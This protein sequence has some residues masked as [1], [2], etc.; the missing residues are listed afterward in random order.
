[1]SEGKLLNERW[2]GH[3]LVG[4]FVLAAFFFFGWLL[5]SQQDRVDRYHIVAEFNTIKNLSE[6]TQVKLRGFTI[7]QVQQ[8]A[9]D[10]QPAAGEAYFRVVLGIEKTYPVP[11]GTIAEI[12][13]SGL[14]GDTFIHLDV[15]QAD[16]A[17]LPAGARIKG[18]DALGMKELV[19][20]ITEMAHK[21]GGAGE[22]IRRADLGYKLGRLGDSGH[23]VARSLGQV[24]QSADSLLIAS[25]TLLE[26][27]GPGFEGVLASLQLSADQLNKTM[28]HTDTLVVGSQEDVRNSLK[29]LRQA[30][31]RLD[32][33]LQRVDQM[34]LYKEAEL[35]STL[36]NLHAA[37]KA[38]RAISEHPWKLL[39]GQGQPK[40]EDGDE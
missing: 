24:S 14:V 17:A 34:V 7:G 8:V 25:R 36:T 6:A 40:S 19:A 2:S 16:G 29:S 33:V 1:M 21:L 4:L 15:T 9:F 30:V 23:Q 13:S 32:Q 38:V 11:A 37:S 5:L 31:A 18:R 39:T 26:A 28:Q 22:S 35:D 10:P 27:M 3:A 20:S 12:R